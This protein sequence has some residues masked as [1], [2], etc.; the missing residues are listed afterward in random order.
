MLKKYENFQD[1]IKIVFLNTDDW[2]G[3]Y[4]D[5]ELKSEGHSMTAYDMLEIL[6]IKH[7]SIYVGDEKF[8]ELFGSSC[9]DTF[10]E[11]KLALDAKKYNL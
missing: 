6:K 3:I 5:G 2:S 4:V 7:E 10:D 1:D 9:P 8:E 11:V